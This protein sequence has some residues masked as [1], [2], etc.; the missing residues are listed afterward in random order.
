MKTTTSSKI[1][2]NL[3]VALTAT[4]FILVVMVISYISWFA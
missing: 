4:G 3:Q 1:S 2:E